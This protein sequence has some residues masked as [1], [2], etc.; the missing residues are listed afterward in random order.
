[1]RWSTGR[2]TLYAIILLFYPMLD[3]SISEDDPC[4]RWTSFFT[5][6]LVGVEAKRRHAGELLIVPWTMQELI[7]DLDR[8]GHS[9]EP[10]VGRPGY[11]QHRLYL[12]VEGR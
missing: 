4:D 12:A 1:M 10:D 6:R 3:D 7:L 11:A 8:C 5:A 2:K 9:L